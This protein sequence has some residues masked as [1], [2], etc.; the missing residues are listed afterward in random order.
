MRIRDL[1]VGA[2]GG[3]VAAHLWDPDR[4]RARRARLHD[5]TAGA[6]RH[7][8]RRLAREGRRRVR[9]SEGRARGLWHRVTP[10]ARP[11]PDDGTLAQKVRSEVLGRGQFHQLDVHV[12][13]HNGVVHLRGEVPSQMRIG[14]LIRAVEAVDGIRRV[15]SFLHL[16][17]QVAPNK[18]GAHLA[19]VTNH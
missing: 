17:G 7:V 13:T 8:R 16:P 5:Q 10:H 19:E 4:G 11:T 3:A 1:T 14:E 15:E 2:V 12:D 6:L 18:Q 9:Y